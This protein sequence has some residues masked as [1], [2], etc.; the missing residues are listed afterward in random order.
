[1]SMRQKR[2]QRR[3]LSVIR[4][5]NDAHGIPLQNL[6]EGMDISDDA[7]LTLHVCPSRPHCPCCLYDLQALR[8]NLLNTKGVIGVRLEIIGIPDASRWTRTL[9]EE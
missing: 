3:I 7:K 1:M 9:N 6:I 2:L 4:G 8:E 5:W